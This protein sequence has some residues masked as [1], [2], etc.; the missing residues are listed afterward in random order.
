MLSQNIFYTGNRKDQVLHVG[1]RTKCSSLNND[2]YQKGINESPL[3]LCGHCENADH[4][5]MKCHNYQA[6]KVELVLAVSQH[7]SV[8]LQ[9]LLFGS[10]LPMNVNIEIFEAVQTYIVNTKRYYHNTYHIEVLKRKVGKML[11]GFRFLP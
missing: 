6:Q 4:F 2:L 9:T 10:D 1:I 5:L 8:T 11:Q 7:T 3:C